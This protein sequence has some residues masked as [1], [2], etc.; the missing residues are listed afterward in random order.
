M[1]TDEK[2]PLL[3]NSFI[4]LLELMRPQDLVSIVTYSG[5]ATI[6]LPPTSSIER[7]Q[8]VEVLV[9]LTSEGK[10]DALE[11][12]VLA[13]R[14]AQ[15]GFIPEGNNRIIMASDGY[16]RIPDALPRLV[17]DKAKQGIHMSVFF[18]GQ[19]EA[20]I[21]DRLDRLARIGEGNFRHIQADNASRM[22]IEEAN[23]VKE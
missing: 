6:A 15:N 18:F 2:L 1:N 7:S 12:V 9:N 14:V 19:A 3:V 16:F 21:T 23:A 10:T 22:L 13:Y 20:K 5:K 8:I 11:G 17:G 4:Q